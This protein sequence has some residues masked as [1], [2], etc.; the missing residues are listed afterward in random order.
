MFA[1]VS[2]SGT[3]ILHGHYRAYVKVQPH[4]NPSVFHKLL[5]S[6]TKA[7][8]KQ[9]VEAK[10]E[11]SS[12]P[13]SFKDGSSW[14]AEKHG[15][16]SSSVSLC[17][18]AGR[19]DD[20]QDAYICDQVF[21]GTAGNKTSASKSKYLENDIDDIRITQ[22]KSHAD[23]SRKFDLCVSDQVKSETTWD[24]DEHGSFWLE[25]DD[26]CIKVMEE[27]AFIEKLEERDG[28][29]IGTPYVLFYHKQLV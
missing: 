22:L 5:N 20:D 8:E 29:L 14:A 16:I 27:Q 2:H 23:V 15:I 1:I 3:S 24:S 18:N 7:E 6:K 19:C 9:R 11:T 17:K 12:N 4:V 21:N 25:C 10:M 26:E 28:C 13:D